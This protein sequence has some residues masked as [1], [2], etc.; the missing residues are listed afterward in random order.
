MDEST[1]KQSEWD[2]DGDDGTDRGD[3]LETTQG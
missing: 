1:S 2:Y 3:C